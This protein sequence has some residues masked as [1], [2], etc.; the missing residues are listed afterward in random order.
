MSQVAQAHSLVRTHTHTLTNTHSLS[1]H[2]S[3]CPNSRRSRTS[4]TCVTPSASHAAAWGSPGHSSKTPTGHQR[5]RGRPMPRGEGGGEWW[6]GEAQFFAQHDF[7]MRRGEGCGWEVG[8]HC[9][10]SVY[11]CVWRVYTPI[12][13][14]P[15]RTPTL[16]AHPSHS[17]PPPQ[18]PRPRRHPPRPHPRGCGGKGSHEKGTGQ[19]ITRE[20]TL[21]K[22]VERSHGA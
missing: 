2:P 15:H 20:A 8:E 4:P 21:A 1:S 10:R 13:T 19:D 14:H 6:V 18:R 7:S 9:L 22:L 3:L 5:P 16:T 12:T 17:L 11:L